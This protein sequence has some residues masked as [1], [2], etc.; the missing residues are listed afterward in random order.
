[1]QVELRGP[2]GF[3]ARVD[4]WYDE[5]A[6][7]VEFDGRVKY[8]EPFAGRSAADVLWEEKRR[9]DAIRD[10]GI[11]MV[12]IVQADVGAAWPATADRLRSLLGVPLVGAR[13]FSVVRKPD[14]RLRLG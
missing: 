11:R 8:D 7:A 14:W 6:V 1:L 3:L 9:E 13:R 12:R 5:A 10:L 2:R 4:G